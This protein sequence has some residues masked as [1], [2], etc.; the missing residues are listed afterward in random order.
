MTTA[1]G[2]SVGATDVA[3]TDAI[4]DDTETVAAVLTVPGTNLVTN[5]VLLDA[6]VEVGPGA[7]STRITVRVRRGIDETG[8]TV[9]T[10]DN[11]AL[12]A[13]D[14]LATCVGGGIDEL[15]EGVVFQSYALTVQTADAS[16]VGTI[17]RLL[18]SATVF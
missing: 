10:F 1:W 16:A 9:G 8:D 12:P 6:K 15:G 17:G 18:F 2:V 5:Q 3:V 13:E 11:G 4:V 7:D 14:T